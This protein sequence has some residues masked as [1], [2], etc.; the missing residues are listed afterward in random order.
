[1]TRIARAQLL[2]LLV[3]AL[4]ACGPADTEPAYRSSGSWERLP[5]PPLSPRETALAL[6]IDGEALIMGGSDAEPCPPNA[7]CV[8]PTDPPL[9][10]GA[11]FEPSRRRWERIA[12]APVG[13]SFAYGAAIDGAVYV[14]AHGERQ[15]P[16]APA[17]FLRYRRP[18]DRWTQ[19]A[20]PPDARRRF[21]VATDEHVVAYAESDEGS[22]IPD[23]IFDPASGEWAELPDDPLPPSFGRTMAWSGRELVLFAHE[24]VPQPG[25]R[26]PSVVIAAAFDPDR[27]TWRRLPDSE[28]LGGGARWFA[29][30]GR[31]IFPALGSADGGDVG[32]WGRPYP[33][34]GVLDPERG[35][36]LELRD[37][38]A[39]DEEF[40][41]GVVAGRQ[42]DFFGHD[43]WIL[44]AVA[45][46][47]IRIPPLD[48]DEQRVSGRSVTAAG[49]NMIVF[50]GVRWENG[51]M[52]GELLDEA[53]MWAPP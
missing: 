20:L 44:D 52:R 41:A 23:V 42:A 26:E 39:G 30:D 11:A 19:L 7:G 46:D 22:Q 29:H 21:I 5:E 28:M 45:Q 38:P 49:R 33:N 48:R 50:G 6:S 47:W 32:N 34:G 24:L 35:R 25:S 16:H 4:G 51:G 1:M 53:W 12:H 37:A 14:L 17:V 27:R 3:A 2:V 13:F 43:G 31:L 9:R 40:A 15:R 10:D 18:D 36:W 8:A